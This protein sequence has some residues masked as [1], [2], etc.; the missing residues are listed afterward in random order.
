MFTALLV[1]GLLQAAQVPDDVARTV[2]VRFLAAQAPAFGAMQ[3]GQLIL[4]REAADPAVGDGQAQVLYRIYNVAA[5]GFVIISGDDRVLP[6]LGYSTEGPFAD[7]TLPINLAKWL[8]GYRTEVR[9]A[10]QMEDDPARAA[11]QE[12]ARWEHGVPDN[13]GAP[14]AAVAPLLSTTWNQSPHYN[15]LCPG[16]SVT[17]CVATAM[18]QVMKYHNWPA[19][20]LGFHSYNAPNYGTLSANF[21]ATTYNWAGM[22]NNVTSANNAVATLMFHC[23][24]A[25]DMQYSPQVSGAWVIQ[26]NSPSTDHNAEYALKTYFNYDP[27]MQGLKRA[28]YSEAQWIAKLK[29]DLD[30]SRPVLYDG[31]G[32]GGGHC[33]VADG[34]DNNNYFHFNWGW[35][36]AYDG[37]FT[38]GALN[39]D[40]QGTG[41]GTGA[42][43][44]G[45]EAIFGVKPASGGGG[46]T[47][48]QQTFNLGLYTWVSPS[49]STIYYGQAFSV[50]TNVI[51]NGTADFSGDYCA[52]VFD[53]NSNFYGYVQTLT[54]YTLPAGYVYNNN[55]VFSTNGLLT[56]LPGTY[57]IGILYRPTNGEWV[58]VNN[59]QGYTN[60][61]QINVTNPNDMEL[62][63]NLTVTPGTSLAQGSQISV[64]TNFINDG[65]NTFTGQYGVGL[66][67]LD[68][69]WAQDVG[70]LTENQGLPSGYT[71]TNNLTFGPATVTVQPGTYLLAAQHNPNGGGWQLTG[72]SYY[73]NPIFVTVTASAIQPD[74]YEVNNTVAQAHAFPVSF[75]GNS[76]SVA[77]TGSNFHNTTDQ[78][79]YK[80][81]LPAGYSYTISPRMHDAYN[82][83]NGQTYTVDGMF[84]YSLDGN[85]WSSVYDDIMPGTINL[86][87]G[88]T[89]YFHCAP[90]FLGLTG[91]YL[92]QLNM[93][94]DGSVGIT[95]QPAAPEL[96]IFP[97]PAQDQVTVD[98][99]G[100]R[101]SRLA[102]EVLDAQG[103][104]VAQ[105][106]FHRMADDRLRLSLADVP[107]GAYFLRLTTGAEVHTGRLILVR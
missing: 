56:M 76:A 41:G 105:P 21:G 100:G 79:L 97:N 88:G 14:R 104:L 103:R 7:D 70:V 20:G 38:V 99:P 24:V 2:A 28:N 61:P 107:A 22:P 92:L 45:Q 50:N 73:T 12:W 93:T 43:N 90:Y 91:T 46:G 5:Q 64:A 26:A 96:R 11:L 85:T 18:A 89:V 35:G 106:A 49:A 29:A 71:Y 10:L 37:Y 82:S 65:W 44:S 83:G 60:F 81:V 98:L 3:P 9:A 78:D 1:A 86:P 6:V 94:R 27:S 101:S 30:A 75:S 69:T 68:G 51:N 66:F 25:V 95:E 40:G 63:A 102:V 55:L 53:A 62:N 32:S 36:G 57:Y 17:G 15:A 19:Q 4:A 48:G 39:P 58:L 13:T 67:N 47:G 42:Y 52:A 33:F 54:G 77:T 34:Y 23:G 8:E 72:S 84:S 87:N 80:V 59:N 16:G 31:F 74:P